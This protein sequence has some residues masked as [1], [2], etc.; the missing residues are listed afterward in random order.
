M[1]DKIKQEISALVDGE[2][3]AADY[4]ALRDALRQDEHCQCWHRYHLIGDTLKKQLPDT[5]NHDLFQRVHAALEAEPLILSPQANQQSTNDTAAQASAS[6]ASIDKARPRFWARPAIG[7]SVA[8]SVAVAAVVVTQ[9][10][11]GAD[12]TAMPVPGMAASSEAVQTA[13]Q[14]ASLAQ[15]PTGEAAEPQ[16]VAGAEMPTLTLPQSSPVLS[17]D[18][19][20]D[21]QWKRL[22]MFAPPQASPYTPDSKDFSPIPGLRPHAQVVR[23]GEQQQEAQ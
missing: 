6:I 23:F 3:E 5:L 7:L 19:A 14:Q 2:L 11:N 1:T 10:L 8:A 18:L 4:E 22:D 13:P 20:D 16:V 17:I 12:D 9:L 15:A 21:E